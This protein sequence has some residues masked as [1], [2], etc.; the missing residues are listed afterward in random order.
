M[1][2][3]DIYEASLLTSVNGQ[4]CANVLHFRIAT[5]PATVDPAEDLAEA[6]QTNLF[7]GVLAPAWSG[8]CILQ[9]IRTRKIAPAPG[10]A[11]I[12]PVNQPGDGTG[13]TLPPNNSVVLTLYSARADR[14]G[15]GRLHLSGV[16]ETNV[17]DGLLSVAAAALYVAI[18]NALM[19]NISGADGGIYTPG[20]YSKTVPEFNTITRF[21]VRSWIHTLRGRRMIAP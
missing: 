1:S 8:D 4:K 11:I 5:M 13:D 3:G 9:Q 15:R 2:V 10:G 16:E 20:I 6:I 7:A 18:G 12:R 17:Q 21:Q 19:S 14:S